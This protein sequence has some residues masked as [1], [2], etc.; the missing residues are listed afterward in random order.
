MEHG[1]PPFSVSSSAEDRVHVVS[2]A[3]ELDLATAPELRAALDVAEA[4]AAHAIT[5]D[6]SEVDFIDSTGVAV[7]IEYTARSRA[8]GDR[9]RILA[10]PAV[11]HVLDVS[12]TRSHLP[13]LE[14]T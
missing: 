13:L 3:G 11:E 1:V 10:G 6:L 2:V 8:N 14:P 7:L 4:G 9:L 5:L 12:G